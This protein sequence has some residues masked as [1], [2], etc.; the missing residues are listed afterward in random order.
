M[1][2]KEPRAASS[3]KMEI[4]SGMLFDAKLSMTF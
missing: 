2:D 1:R 4:L 3:N